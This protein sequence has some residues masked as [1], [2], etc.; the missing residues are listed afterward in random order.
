MAAD[1]APS[2]RRDLA[3]MI[4]PLERALIAAELPVLRAHGLTM[5][6]YTVLSALDGQPVRTQATLARAIGAD[7]TRI[8]GVL[9]GLQRQGLIE[10]EPDATDRRA[11]LVSITA[12]GRRLRAT[13]QADIQRNEERVL[14]QLSAGDRGGF[15][16]ALQFLSSLP[17]EV[18]AGSAA[19]R[20]G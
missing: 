18:I 19:Q 11:N 4:A 20:R 6:G 16:R 14:A 7:K 5:W 1:T 15:L 9:D 12:E 17:P 13:A 8:I 10:R 3:A 2:G